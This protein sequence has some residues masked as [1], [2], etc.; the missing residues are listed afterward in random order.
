MLK[1]RKILELVTAGLFAILTVYLVLEN[2]KLF[3]QG[4][5]TLDNVILLLVSIIGIRVFSSNM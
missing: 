5:L 1:P 2:I 3:H 4:T